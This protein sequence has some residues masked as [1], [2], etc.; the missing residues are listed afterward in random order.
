[1]PSHTDHGISK[2]ATDRRGSQSCASAHPPA[3]T[4][5]LLRGSPTT[6]TVRFSSPV[7]TVRE[8]GSPSPGDAIRTRNG[9]LSM[10]TPFTSRIVN[11]LLE[12]RHLGDHLDHGILVLTNHFGERGLPFLFRRRLRLHGGHTKRKQHRGANQNETTLSP[13]SPHVRHVPSQ[14][15]VSFPVPLTTIVCGG[16]YFSLLFE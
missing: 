1:V 3:P 11:S 7:C 4:S 16:Y 8:R 12:L 15:S 5:L 6:E 10:A 2:N 9:I 14:A 13:A